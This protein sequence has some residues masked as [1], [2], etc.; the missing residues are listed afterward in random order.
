MNSLNTGWS[1]H[2]GVTSNDV[3]AAVKELSVEIAPA[4]KSADLDTAV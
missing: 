1:E 4:T 3:A 2:E